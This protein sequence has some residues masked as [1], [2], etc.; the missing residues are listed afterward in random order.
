[1][2]IKLVHLKFP[3]PVVHNKCKK[4]QL[5]NSLSVLDTDMNQCSICLNDVRETRNS[6]A[7]RCGHVFHSHCLENWKKMGK[8]TCPICRKVFDGS[9]FRVQ[10]TVFNDYEATSNTVCLTNELVLDALDLIF[11]VEHEEDLTSVLGDFGMSMSDFDPS[12]F[13]TE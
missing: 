8:V 9:K 3:S 4:N 10:I 11:N 6:K 12:V 2:H 13:D 1:M 7:I 5:I